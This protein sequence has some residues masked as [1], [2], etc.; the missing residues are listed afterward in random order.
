VKKLDIPL[1]PQRRVP[2]E[3]RV[4]GE[5]F[6]SGAGV[7]FDASLADLAQLPLPRF[8]RPVDPFRMKFSKRSG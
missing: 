5:F 4:G 1:F 3:R 6:L 7:S 2:L 8:E